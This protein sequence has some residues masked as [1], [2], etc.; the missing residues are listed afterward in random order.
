ML[1]QSLF[2]SV[3]PSVSSLSLSRTIP[4]RHTQNLNASTDMHTRTRNTLV[5]PSKATSHLNDVTQAAPLRLARACVLGD[6]VGEPVGKGRSRCE[7]N[8]SVVQI[9][10]IGK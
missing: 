5:I 9:V 3:I 2:L 6:G 1:S 8:M 10:R 4:Y 7:R